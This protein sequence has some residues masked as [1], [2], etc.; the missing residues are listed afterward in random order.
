MPLVLNLDVRWRSGRLV[1]VRC[2]M[3]PLIGYRSVPSD[4]AEA[5]ELPLDAGDVASLESFKEY[6][7]KVT[8]LSPNDGHVRIS[9]SLPQ[10]SP[11]SSSGR[12][13]GVSGAL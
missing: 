8:R 6:L 5:D 3:M 10:Q 2:R 4:G 1:H 11:N 7:R 13:D 12:S 9:L